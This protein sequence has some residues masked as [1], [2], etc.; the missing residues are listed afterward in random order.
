MNFRM[1]GDLCEKIA[2]YFSFVND[3]HDVVYFLDAWEESQNEVHMSLRDAICRGDFNAVRTILSELGNN[4]EFVINMA[5]NGSSTLLYW[6]VNYIYQYI[7]FFEDKFYQIYKSF[8]LTFILFF[9]H[10]K[11]KKVLYQ[12]TLIFTNIG[13][14]LCYLCVFAIFLVPVN[15]VEKT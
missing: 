8:S 9:H 1:T 13:V 4:A 5:P 3:P 10:D 2:K 14:V 11:Y 12:I 15:W 7:F 6:L